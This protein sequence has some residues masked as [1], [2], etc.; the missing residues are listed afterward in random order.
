MDR[1]SYFQQESK[2]MIGTRLSVFMLLCKMIGILIAAVLLS[3]VTFSAA[4]AQSVVKV[5]QYEKSTGIIDMGSD[6][7]IRIGDVFEVNRYT[8]DF[9]FWVGRVE[10][11]L[12]RPK[13]AGIK[14]VA[15]AENAAIQAGDVLELRKREYDP[16]LDKLGQ[17]KKNDES[18]AVSLPLPQNNMTAS[19]AK[20]AE[21]PSHH[22]DPVRFGITSGVLRPLK[23]SSESL[24]L[25]L[26]LQ[27]RD[28]N[29]N[30]VS[31]VD[32]RNAY[33][34]SLSFEAFFALPLSDRLV[35][36][37]NY[38]YVP[39]NIKSAV[40]SNLL[41]VG[42]TASASM[43]KIST[44]V[45]YRPTP[46]L[47]YGL[48]V[49]LFLPEVT[50]RGS[51][52]SLTMNDRQ[53]GIAADVAYMIPVRSTIWLKSALEYNIFFDDGPAIHYLTLRI[54]PSFAIGK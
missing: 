22:T 12:V 3:S 17:T 38:A 16:L 46:R 44:A 51:R 54:G 5:L 53:W 1:L 29:N 31:V 14:M 41:S 10:V 11:I 42:L 6:D 37:L 39:L 27:V 20:V 40:E 35:M 19:N 24:G 45:D 4:T 52:Q 48:G 8:G 50:V 32:M 9:V 28:P 7:G 34:S 21:H 2:K 13:R 26:Q 43:L 18:S 25:N 33:S 15:Q 36:N 47:Q 49:G 23:R 30:I